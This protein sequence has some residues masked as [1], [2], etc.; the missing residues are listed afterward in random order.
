MTGRLDTGHPPPRCHWPRRGRR[1][2]IH[3]E[4]FCR[5]SG[6]LGYQARLFDVSRHGCK[7][8]FIGRPKLD[9][10][11][12]VKFSGLQA[13]P[14]YVCW[15]DGFIGGVEFDKAIHAAVFEQLLA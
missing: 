15:V 5:R 11:V 10:K 14:A 13:L 6:Q 4:V 2:T 7:I 9:D 12:W 3:A 1:E 8:E